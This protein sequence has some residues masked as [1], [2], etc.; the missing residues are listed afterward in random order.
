MKDPNVEGL[1]HALAA[2]SDGSGHEVWGPGPVGQKLHDKGLR[3][4]ALAFDT[5]AIVAVQLG[6]GGRVRMTRT[7]RLLAPVLLEAINGDDVG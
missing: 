4:A 1:K 7:I 2:L 6:H 3:Q 5:A